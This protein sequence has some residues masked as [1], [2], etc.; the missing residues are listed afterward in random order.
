[1]APPAAWEQGQGDGVQLRAIRKMGHSDSNAYKWA[2]FKVKYAYWVAKDQRPILHSKQATWCIYYE[3]SV[4]LAK[5]YTTIEINKDVSGRNN[6][7]RQK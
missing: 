7:T 1:M 4:K 2:S 5:L 6:Y 3:K